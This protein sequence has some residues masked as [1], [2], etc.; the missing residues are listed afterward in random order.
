[1]SSAAL[2]SSWL[3]CAC[4]T[5]TGLRSITMIC[6]SGANSWISPAAQR[7]YRYQADASPTR[8]P[9]RASANSARYC[10]WVIRP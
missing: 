3:C 8:W 1:M 6:A 9:S 5:S 4:I 2:K 10:S 7:E